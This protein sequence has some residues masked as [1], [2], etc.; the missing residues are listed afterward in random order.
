MEVV[1]GEFGPAGVLGDLGFLDELGPEALGDGLDGEVGDGFGGVLGTA[2][3]DFLGELVRGEV[4]EP[5]DEEF[6]L[7][8]ELVELAGA[9]GGEF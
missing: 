5:I 3:L 9:P 8:I 4:G 2:L 7:V 6:E 1:F